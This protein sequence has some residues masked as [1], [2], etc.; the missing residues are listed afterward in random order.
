VPGIC[1]FNIITVYVDDYT[2]SGGEP[3]I[4]EKKPHPNYI[5]NRV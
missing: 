2:L 5:R 3:E 4:D 1:G